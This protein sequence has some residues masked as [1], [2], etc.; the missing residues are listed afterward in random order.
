MVNA[1][2]YTMGMRTN[3]SKIIKDLHKA[4]WINA[5]LADE[6]QCSRAYI[7]QLAKGHRKQPNYDIGRQL[8]ELHEQGTGP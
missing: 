2:D 5:Y 1:S 3:F 4:G 7:G 8:V 6:C